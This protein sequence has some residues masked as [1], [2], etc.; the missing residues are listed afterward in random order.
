MH[1]GI[2]PGSGP[3]PR[4]DPTPTGRRVVGRCGPL[5]PLAEDGDGNSF[6][7]RGVSA[8]VGL[9]AEGSVGRPYLPTEVAFELE[10]PGSGSVDEKNEGA[11]H[12]ERVQHPGPRL[13]LARSSSGHSRSP[14]TNRRGVGNLTCAEKRNVIESEKHLYELA[15]TLGGSREFV[16]ADPLRRS[17]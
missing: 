10:L 2:Q 6:D 7:P 12:A 9:D 16:A 14:Y 8:T 3:S 17:S 13:G 11:Q 5:E 15:Y 1:L 4:L